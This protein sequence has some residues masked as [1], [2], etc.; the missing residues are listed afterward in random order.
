MNRGVDGFIPSAPALTHEWTHVSGRFSE[1][2]LFAGDQVAAELVEL[3]L[4][5]VKGLPLCR[6]FRV[7]PQ[8]S[9]PLALILHKNIL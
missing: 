3:E 7:A 1:G 5:F 8:V 9:T 4:H 6:V 2:N